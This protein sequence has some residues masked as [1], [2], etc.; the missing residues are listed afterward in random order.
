MLNKR[1]NKTKDEN[2][3]IIYIIEFKDGCYQQLKIAQMIQNIIVI[4][5]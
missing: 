3:P 5:I 2:S 4:C 1:Y